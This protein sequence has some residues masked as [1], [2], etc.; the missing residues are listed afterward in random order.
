L[1]AIKYNS[2]IQVFGYSDRIG[3]E[4]YNKKLALA[5]ADNVKNYLQTKAKGAKFEV[6]GVGE[7]ILLFDNDSPI[8]RNLSRTVQVYIVTPKEK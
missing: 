8:G 3:E 5:R 4:D 1:P 2:T 7:N 6:F